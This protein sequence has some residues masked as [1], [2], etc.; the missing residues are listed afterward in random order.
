LFEGEWNYVKS[1]WVRMR[2]EACCKAMGLKKGKL[3]MPNTRM[4]V[5]V[6]V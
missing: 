3:Y 6:F 5:V 4:A 2:E 1:G